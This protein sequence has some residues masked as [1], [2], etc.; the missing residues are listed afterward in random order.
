[1]LISYSATSMLGQSPAIQVT[2]V[3]LPVVQQ[4]AEPQQ[5]VDYQPPAQAPVDVHCWTHDQRAAQ[6]FSLEG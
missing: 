6:R 1:M 4:P 5:N 2:L 3:D